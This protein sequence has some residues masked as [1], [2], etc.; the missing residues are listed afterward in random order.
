VGWHR[1]G[2]GGAVQREGERENGTGTHGEKQ[3]RKET[4]RRVQF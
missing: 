1:E 3:E 2:G 4:K